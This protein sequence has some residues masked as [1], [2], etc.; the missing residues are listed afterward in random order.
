[1][2]RIFFRT[3]LLTVGFVLAACARSGHPQAVTQPADAPASAAPTANA[4]TA[5]VPAAATEA[6]AATNAA[7]AAP[8]AQTVPGV[9]VFLDPVTGEARKPTRTE[10]ATGAAAGRVQRES[11][12]GQAASEGGSRREEFLLPDGTV[13]VKMNKS[14]YHSVKVCLQPDGSYGEN[15]PPA[16]KAAQP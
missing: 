5:A 6:G 10:A 4:P 2:G 13:G 9:R 12:G 15:C 16:S 11:A 7:P 3:A 1:M 8:T 14:D